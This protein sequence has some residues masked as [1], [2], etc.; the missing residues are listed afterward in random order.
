[1]SGR[2]GGS[3]PTDTW[4]P[5]FRA[6]YTVDTGWAGSPDLHIVG[7]QMSSVSAPVI[8][9]A[10][11]DAAPAFPFDRVDR[12]AELL[13]TLAARRIVI[14]FLSR[15]TRAEVEGI[16]QSLGIF[17]PFVCESGSGAFVPRRYFGGDLAH[18]RSVDG[19]QAIDFGSL[20][21]P[22]CGGTV[23]VAPYASRREYDEP[24]PGAGAAVQA[25]TALYRAAFGAFET[26]TAGMGATSAPHTQVEWL[27]RIV[28]DVEHLCRP[29]RAV[30]APGFPAAVAP[31]SRPRGIVPG[32]PPS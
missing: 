21:P 13:E 19:Y 26:V 10:D 4:I 23:L 17:H 14:V 22:D 24:V 12:L 20:R 7:S 15:R 1:M 25:L 6:R 28:Q 32:A 3:S 8:V 31:K 11:V 9:F 16:R 18:A 2:R 27:E 5:P 30:A 29:A